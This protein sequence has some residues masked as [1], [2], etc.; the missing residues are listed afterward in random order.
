MLIRR[1]AYRVINRTDLVA[2]VHDHMCTNGISDNVQHKTFDWLEHIHSLANT[3][4]SLIETVNHFH[5]Y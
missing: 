3:R 2:R 4:I 1:M 5:G